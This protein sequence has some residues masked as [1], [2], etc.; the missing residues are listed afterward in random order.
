MALR[1]ELEPRAKQAKTATDYVTLANAALAEPAD[2]GFASEMLNKAE[3]Q[4]QFPADY[5]VTAEAF[6]QGLK[7][8]DHARELYE[9][10][11]EAC[12]E[13]AE[14]AALGH[15]IASTLGDKD[16]GRELLQRA[17]ADAKDMATFLMLARYANEDLQ[18]PELAKQFS[19]KVE[20]QLKTLADYRKVV[21][22][23]AGSDPE[24]TKAL[25]KKAARFASGIPGS[26]E[27]AQG[28]LQLFKDEAWAKQT[29]ADLETDCQFPKDFAQLAA[30]YKQL[31]S[32]EAKARELLSQG[33]D[34][35]MS[36]E[37]HIDQARGWAQVVGDKQAAAAA[38]GRA[39]QETQNAAALLALAKTI[40]TETGN[41]ALA[42]KAYAKAETKMTSGPDIMKLAQAVMD[43][44]QDRELASQ[45]YAKAEA[46]LTQ[47]GDLM[48]LA[49]QVLS[50]LGD[51]ARATGIYRKAEGKSTDLAGV[52]KLADEVLQ[53]LGD[54]DYARELLLK[55][56]Q[57]EP[58]TA[59][60]LALTGRAISTL[61]DQEFATRLVKTA[62]T[63][64][65]S[66]ED[67]RKVAA[68]VKQ[69]FADDAEW[70]AEV[71][72]KVKK[73]EANQAK[74]TE[75]QT[76]EKQTSTLKQYLLLVQQ[77]MEQLEDVHYARKLLAAAEEM[78]GKGP[79]NF[80]QYRDLAVAVSQYGQ[81]PDWTERL[82]DAAA[83]HCQNYGCIQEVARSALQDLADRK[84]GQ[85]LARK[86]L[87]AWEQRL[88]KNGQVSVYDYTKL[89]LLVSDELDDT[90]WARK[91]L[92]RAE[93]MAD[94]PLAM[95]H[96]AF[97]VVRLGDESGA[98][99]LYRRATEMCRTA[100]DYIRLAHWVISGP[101]DKETAR[102]LYSEGGER[103][104]NPLER[105]HWAE[106]IV[107]VFKDEDWARQAYDAL[108]PQ[109]TGGNEKQVYQ[110]SRK[111]RLERSIR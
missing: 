96:V 110:A 61:Q 37:E 12:F 105:L 63:R 3:M 51:K 89:A 20:S 111:F 44:L 49:S 35:A 79:Y 23:L 9:Q 6:A 68:A 42:K 21:E 11:E 4:S 108:A 57:M 53:R 106:G 58:G 54:K 93:A 101:G 17:A 32:D 62:D 36:A 55:A 59:E 88:G 71:E 14:F 24:T 43:D 92:E 81:D 72:E 78:L 82:F 97:L 30:G 95:A 2:P 84:L 83:G 50:H 107:E 60:L 67:M 39:L 94:E 8:L 85:R 56:E 66:L 34:L 87:E 29:L 86:Y 100:E 16:K 76:R 99:R 69:H 48:N 52:L 91:L 15:S 27:Y 80:Y 45:V 65:T 41:Q 70:L 103:L 7:D 13:P 10:A 47:P 73:R 25:Y 102:E 74:Y 33:E 22:A 5:I 31:L 77:V 38:F 98:Q 26:V 1:S 40:L 64:V 90:A 28:I 19:A 109:F 18:D 75:F 46:A 104:Q